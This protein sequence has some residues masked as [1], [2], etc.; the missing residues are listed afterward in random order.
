MVMATKADG[1][2]AKAAECD[3]WAKRT[4]NPVARQRYIE[5][6]RGW[7]ELAIYVESVGWNPPEVA[8]QVA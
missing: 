4:K 6:A 7:R 8:R 5:T 2:R 3:Q 1:Y